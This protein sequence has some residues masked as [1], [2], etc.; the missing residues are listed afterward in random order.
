MLALAGLVDGP[1]VP[2]HGAPTDRAFVTAQQVDLAA[3][4]DLARE[5]H[6]AGMTVEDAAAAGG[7]FPEATLVEAFGRAWKQ[8]EER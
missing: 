6:D 4:A 3:V 2:G 5:R 1:V 7:P 8:L